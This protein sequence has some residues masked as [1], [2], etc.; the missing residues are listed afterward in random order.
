VEQRPGHANTAWG[1]WS[2]DGFGLLEFLRLAEDIGAQP[3]LAVYAGYALNGQHVSEA[4][5]DKYIQ[6][7]LDEIQYAIGDTS[8]TWGAKRAADGHPQP[9]DLHYVEVGNEDW[10][11]GSGSYAWR[12]SRM[13]EAIKAAYP[14]LQVV[15]TTGGY[16]GGAASST[17][18]GVTPD[19]VDDHY[20]APPSFF[21]DAATRYDKADR[22][23]PQVLIGE[24]GA[25]DGSPTG[26]LRA[27]VG[28][29][30]FLTGLERNSDIVIGSMYAPV[31]VHESDSNWPV[32]LIGIDAAS[33]YG[34]PSYWVQQMFS[35]NLGGSVVGSRL[36]GA[37]SVQQVVTKSV[38]NGVTTF[39]VKLVN[40]TAQI[41][42]ARLSFFG[43][44]RVDPSATL[45]QLT[46]DPAARNTLTD[47]DAIVPHTERI[48][49]DR[50]TLPANSVTVLRVTA[51]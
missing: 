51:R 39:Y 44:R 28:E 4:D 37:A 46:G 26:T 23:G 5:Y 1:Y 14:Q 50:L 19:L 33:S 27:A 3:L 31:I 41:Q 49:L 35:T 9:F 12:F 43:V 34:S 32:N 29:A 8:T 11:D 22:S 17:P 24:Y 2:T 30:A 18:T 25:Q 42:S 13:Y 40:A 15:A 6:D 48:S 21:V 16:Q 20:Y 7:A 47:P 10:F 45:I 36:G 38:H